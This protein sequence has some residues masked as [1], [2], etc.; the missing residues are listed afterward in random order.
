MSKHP[1]QWNFVLTAAV[2]SM[3]ILGWGVRSKL[4]AD[5]VWRPRYSHAGIRGRAALC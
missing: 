3:T 5:P 2:L 1:R 4:C